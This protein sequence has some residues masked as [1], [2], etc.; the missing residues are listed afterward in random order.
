MKIEQESR[1]ADALRALG[2]KVPAHWSIEVQAR[3]DSTNS[4]LVRRSDPTPVALFALEQTAGRG[5][6]GRIW[7]ARPGDSLTFSLAFDFPCRAD[8]LAGLSLAVGVAL[9]DALV[10]QGVD[11]IALKWPNDLM[12]HGG[13]LGG[14]LI[15]LASASGGGTRA[16]IGV[17]LN[18]APP[19]EGDYASP[20]VALYADTPGQ[21]DWLRLAAALLDALADALP[22]FADQGFAAF[23]ERW[24]GYNLHAGRD[25]VMLDEPQAHLVLLRG[26]CVGVDRD[27][28]LLLDCGGR[29]ERVLAGDVS[30]RAD[31]T[32]AR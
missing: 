27:G 31:P 32:G 10:A 5:R 15:E 2:R 26:R 11:G 3:C 8:A 22:L 12:R 29:I 16:V 28:A 4:E 14:I 13:K 23:S 25:V 24:N 19:A 6:R 17:G 18:L 30:L 20:P 21:D 9:A 7:S 1:S